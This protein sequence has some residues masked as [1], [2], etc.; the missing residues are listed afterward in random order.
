MIDPEFLDELDRFQTGRKR[1]VE[2]RLPGEE[3]SPEVGEGLTFSDYRRYTPGDDTR[4]IDWKLYARTRELYVKVFE[5]ERNFT[6]HVL[7]DASESMDFGDEADSKFDRA[8]K[9]G[10]GFCYLTADEGNDFRFSTF[11]DNYDRLDGGSS[12]AG[13]VLEL[14]DRCNDVDPSGEADFEEVF[15]SYAGTIHSRALILIVS[16][17]LGDIDGI[18]AGLSTLSRNRLVLGHVIDPEEWELPVRGDT[19]FDAM[20]Q[21]FS[22][23]AYVSGRLAQEYHTRLEAHVN[24]IAERSEDLLARHELVRTDEEFFDAF[25]RVWVE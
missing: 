17:F 22:R 4:L 21:E 11:T 7:V 3:E 23:R 9:L 16:D 15:E 13:E 10:L 19:I 14:V 5:E 1:H 25:S 24:D 12:S 2:D 18:E 20:E 6:V 8:A